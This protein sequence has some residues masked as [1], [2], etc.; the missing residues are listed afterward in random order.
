MYSMT[1]NR[2]RTCLTADDLEG[3]ITGVGPVACLPQACSELALAIL[4]H[5]LTPRAF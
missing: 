3:Y 2:D 4:L 1:T 5:T